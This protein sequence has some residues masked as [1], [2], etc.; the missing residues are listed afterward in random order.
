MQPRT[1]AITQ[2][3]AA[4]VCSFLFISFLLC[5]LYYRPYPWHVRSQPHNKIKVFPNRCKSFTGK[6]LRRARPAS[7]H[8]S[9]YT[10]RVYGDTRNIFLYF[11]NR[12]QPVQP[13]GGIACC[14][15]HQCNSKKVVQSQF[16]SVYKA[17]SFFR[18]WCVVRILNRSPPMLATR[19]RLA[20]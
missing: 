16:Q 4:F 3:I 15:L 13:L 1:K 12:L 10:P 18:V 11:L 17:C 2:R 19:A 20:G 5:Y 9:P 14:C 7:R 8:L 6:G